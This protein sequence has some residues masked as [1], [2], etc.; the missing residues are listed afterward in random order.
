MFCIFL[1][2]FFSSFLLVELYDFPTRVHAVIL[3]LPWD[4]I[5]VKVVLLNVL[6]W[7]PLDRWCIENLHDNQHDSTTNLIIINCVGCLVISLYFCIFNTQ[8]SDY[9]MLC[10]FIWA[11]ENH[12][13]TYVSKS[14]LN[15]AA[16]AKFKFRY[17]CVGWKPVFKSTYFFFY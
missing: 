4:V 15:A 2:I 17:F 14:V 11:T 10:L 3:S 12:R 1:M 5:V 16:V 7:Q 9:T 8:N 6:N 13:F